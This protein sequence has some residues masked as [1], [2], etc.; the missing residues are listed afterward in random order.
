MRADETPENDADTRAVLSALAALAGTPCAGCQA[1]LCGHLHLF[2][3][4]LGH[5]QAP[6]C[7]R[8]L[9]AELE[10]EGGLLRRELRAQVE[11]KPCLRQGWQRA[12]AQSRCGEPPRCLAGYAESAPDASAADPAAAAA[13]EADDFWDAGAMGCGELVLRLR[14]RMR[15]L[16]SGGVLQLRATDAGA[17]EDLPAWCRMVGHRLVFVKQPDYW[18]ASKE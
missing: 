16:P 12:S 9:A 17:P 10:Q 13:P 15:G 18:I 8:C 6:R 7:L 11:R 3:F 14:L 4:M 1:A 2:S 5:R